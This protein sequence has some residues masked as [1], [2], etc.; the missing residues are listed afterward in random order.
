MAKK[1]K[2]ELMAGRKPSEA[3]G[4]WAASLLQDASQALR[5]CRLRGVSLSLYALRVGGG[6]AALWPEVE[7]TMLGPG[8]EDQSLRGAK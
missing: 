6:G 3:G 8:E 1:K 5:G 4:G 7:A 2:K